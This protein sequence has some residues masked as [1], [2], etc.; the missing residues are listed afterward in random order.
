MFLVEGRS[1]V[2]EAVASGAE[3]H[4][5]FVHE[6]LDDP[7]L[8]QALEVSAATPVTVA[9][10][11]IEMLSETVTPQ[12]VVAVVAAPGHDLEVVRDASLAVV[13]AQVRDPGNAGTLIRSA[14]AAGA[15]AV[16]FSSGSVDP[17]HPK[18][19]RSAAGAVFRVPIV[20][21]VALEE[22][23]TA[24]REAG[25]RIIG[26]STRGGVDL[27][28]VDLA[29][30]SAFVLGNEAWGLPGEVEEA[31]D[32]LVGIPMPGPAE[33]LNVSIAGSILLFEALRQRRPG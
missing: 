33:S 9:R 6:E 30:P 4:D 23:L 22:A 21:S 32:V 31:V 3:V 16:V 26:T 19:V 18:V 27:Y 7:A 2:L 24:L 20:R 17:L 12:G 10:D 14:T 13:L 15:D 1:V 25:I 5:V 11:V 28:E 8:H 29:E